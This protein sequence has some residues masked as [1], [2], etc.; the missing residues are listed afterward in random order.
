MTEIWELQDV[1]YKIEAFHVRM[2]AFDYMS[3]SLILLIS[4]F[5]NVIFPLCCWMLTDSVLVFFHSLVY[6]V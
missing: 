1:M 5:C 3:R 6:F 4:F 2:A